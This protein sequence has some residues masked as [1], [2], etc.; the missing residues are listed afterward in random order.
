MILFILHTTITKTEFAVLS[1][2]E[3][4]AEEL[5]LER[6]L[7]QRCWTALH[8]RFMQTVALPCIVVWVVGLLKRVANTCS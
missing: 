5:W 8:L 4:K 1:C 6:D 2:K 3:L 7:D